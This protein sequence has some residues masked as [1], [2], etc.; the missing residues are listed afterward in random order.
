MH[1]IHHAHA[2]TEEDP[3]SPHFS[4]LIKP[5]LGIPE[6]LPYDHKVTKDLIRDKSQVFTHK[7]YFK[8]N[9]YGLHFRIIILFNRFIITN[10][11]ILLYG[12]CKLMVII[13]CY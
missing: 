3:H 6:E 12:K 5:F 9:W 2:D 10:Y 7:N 13:W 1:R 4:G 8:Y 11:N